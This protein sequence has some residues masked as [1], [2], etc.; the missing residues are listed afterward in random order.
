[1]LSFDEKY[2]QFHADKCGANREKLREFWWWWSWVHTWRWECRHNWSW[3]LRCS[4][5]YFI[6][7][8]IA[9]W[10]VKIWLDNQSCKGSI[11][12]LLANSRNFRSFAQSTSHPNGNFPFEVFQRSTIAPKWAKFR[13]TDKSFFTSEDVINFQLIFI[14]TPLLLRGF[15]Y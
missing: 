3:L 4:Q 10:N 6:W 12:I 14:N 11:W 7:L 5:F 15:T 8:S 1:M 2:G 13:F 9:V